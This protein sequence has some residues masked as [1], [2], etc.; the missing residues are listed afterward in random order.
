MKV[1]RA[2]LA[3]LVAFI[4]HTVIGRYFRWLGGSIDLFTVVAATFGLVHGRMAGIAVGTTAG[5]IQDAFSGGL[6][7]FNGIAKTTVGYLS[8]I[9]GRLIIVR[10]VWAR[11][12]F[13]VAATLVDLAIL[14]AV[15]QLAEQSRVLGEG[16]TPIYVCVSNAVAGILLVRAV[17]PKKAKRS[18]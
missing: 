10:G 18:R 7:G 6:F 13:F 17:E 8:G 1:F 11:A 14:V 5:L 9:V 15:A 4:V 3:I 12:L 16:L 2:A